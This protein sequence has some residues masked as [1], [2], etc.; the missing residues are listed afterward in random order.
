[1]DFKV[2]GRLIDC[3][4]SQRP[5]RPLLHEQHRCSLEHRGGS[6]RATA[7]L[8]ATWPSLRADH[9][10]IVWR[11]TGGGLAATGME[12]LLATCTTILFMSQAHAMNYMCSSK[13][14]C[15]Y[16][17]CANRA[18]NS[19]HS[20]TDWPP[21][22]P[23]GPSPDYCN[24]G[25]WDWGCDYEPDF[26][27]YGGDDWI[28]CP[29]PSP[30]PP[31]FYSA[32]GLQYLG[33]GACKPCDAGTFAP[34]PGATNC[35]SCPDGTYASF[36]ATSCTPISQPPTTAITTWAKSCSSDSDCNFEGCAHRPCNI[37]GRPDLEAACVVNVDLQSS[38][39][40]G[41]WE[42]RCMNGFCYR[43]YDCVP[44]GC[45]SGHSYATCNTSLSDSGSRT[46]DWGKPEYDHCFQPYTWP[47][48]TAG[49]KGMAKTG[50][51]GKLLEVNGYET[52]Q[53]ICN[54][55]CALTHAWQSSIWNP[56]DSWFCF[57]YHEANEVFTPWG[58]NSVLKLV[59]PSPCWNPNSTNYTETSSSYGAVLDHMMMAAQMTGMAA[60][61]P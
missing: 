2:L 28:M 26:C 23:S 9:M 43:A 27:T 53:C 24:N 61:D 29:D 6:P 55:Y 38:Q 14:D 46:S 25:I 22:R 37:T 48:I 18:C 32:N 3:H 5:S 33:D 1:M 21:H 31:G 54:H 35:S 52:W 50:G 13:A 47:E 15:N 49:S 17:G 36:P 45:G 11:K 42:H 4:S 56:Q 59:E 41:V 60:A 40:E 7:P 57:V 34:S 51:L 30:C 16:H 58:P 44:H 10:L 8:A 19:S 20:E 39:H 12:I